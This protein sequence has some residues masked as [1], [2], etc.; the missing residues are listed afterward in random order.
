LSN[1]IHGVEKAKMFPH[2]FHARQIS[3]IAPRMVDEIAEE[4]CI[5]GSYGNGT[6]NV[7][8]NT[9]LSGRCCVVEE[10]IFGGEGCTGYLFGMKSLVVRRSGGS[11]EAKWG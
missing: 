3:L 9:G 2:G 8:A 11:L 5:G 7:P 6:T 10:D 4:E 1:G